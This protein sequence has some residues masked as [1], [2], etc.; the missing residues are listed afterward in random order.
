[1]ART[2]SIRIEEGTLRAEVTGE[3]P[4]NDEEALGE[5][6][7]TWRRIAELCAEQRITHVLAILQLSGPNNSVRAFSMAS[8]LESIGLSRAVRVA[9]VDPDRASLPHS[10]FAARVATSRGWQVQAFDDEVAAAAWLHAC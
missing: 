9:F 8:S 4:L 6:R 1:M 10:Q 5:L 3:R 2:V 7:H